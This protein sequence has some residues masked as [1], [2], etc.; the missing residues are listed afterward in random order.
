MVHFGVK[1]PF[2]WLRNDIGMRLVDFWR[3]RRR[4]ILYFFNNERTE[5]DVLVLNLYGKTLSD[6]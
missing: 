2:V 4:V 5:L 6:F 3:K 1:I